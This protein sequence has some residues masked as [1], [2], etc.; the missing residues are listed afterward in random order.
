MQR[1]H[2]LKILVRE[3]L[4]IIA[5]EKNGASQHVRQTLQLILGDWWGFFLG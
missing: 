5:Q 1:A 3:L 4:L 2:A